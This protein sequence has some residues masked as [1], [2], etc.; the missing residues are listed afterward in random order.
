M[1]QNYSPDNYVEIAIYYYRV[2]CCRDF[3]FRAGGAGVR[4][5]GRRAGSRSPK[6][7][8]QKVVRRSSLG[9]SYSTDRGYV[10]LNY[11]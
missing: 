2:V 11:R 4:A 9:V 7:G 3:G 10:M 8:R 6:D 1:G 5:S